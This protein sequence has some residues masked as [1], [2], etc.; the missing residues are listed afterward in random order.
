[1]IADMERDDGKGVRVAFVPP[2]FL[3]AFYAPPTRA[4]L[5]FLFDCEREWV[6][7]LPHFCAIAFVDLRV[8][9]EMPSD[10]RA[11]AKE[12]TEQFGDR[13]LCTITVV[14]GTG[15]FPA[16]VRSV[17]AGIQLLSRSSSA[18]YVTP[19]LEDALE[20]VHAVAAPRGLVID[21][22]AVAAAAARML[23]APASTRTA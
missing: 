14:E 8:G 18:M 15:F 7:D 4:G 16:L 21:D 19:N 1:M 2:V 12:I 23:A 5:D 10:A 6:A 20:R 9:K 3:S 22:A 13:M 11:R 17:L